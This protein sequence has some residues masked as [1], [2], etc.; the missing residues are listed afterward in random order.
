MKT[1]PN[2]KTLEDYLTLSYPI[3]FSPE[4][5]GGYTVMIQDLPGC[6]S[7]GE[8]FQEAMDNILDAKQQWLKTAIQYQDS[9]PLPG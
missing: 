1:I 5:E 3:T 9:I 6:I 8:T 2:L 7:T 4:E